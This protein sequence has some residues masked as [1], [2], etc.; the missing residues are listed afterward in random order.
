MRLKPKIKF[1]AV[2]VVLLIIAVAAIYAA[3][4]VGLTQGLQ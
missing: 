1:L 2:N 4:S 3:M